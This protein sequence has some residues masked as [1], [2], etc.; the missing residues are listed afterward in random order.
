MKSID[1]YRSAYC[2]FFL[3]LIS[4]IILNSCFIVK[5]EVETDVAPSIILSPKP[6]IEMSETLVRSQ[7]GDM[8]AFLPKDW[9]FVDLEDKISADAFAVAVNPDY[10]L[11]AVFSTIKPNDELNQ[12]VKKEGLIG[13]ARYSIIK[14]QN[15]TADA[16]K[17]YGK[18]TSISMGTLSFCKFSYTA[19]EGAITS[20][21]A[22]FTSS[23]GEYYEFALVPLNVRKLP[24]AGALDTDK[25]FHSIL[26]TIQ[27]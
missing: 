25:I 5:E 8:I 16:V 20:L 3:F 9:F 14:K 27:Y 22:V 2:K 11:A 10:T 15:K 12:L 24:L 19:T 26:T 6:V 17:L 1:T 21:S 23:L 18:Y 7:K 4:A 13:L